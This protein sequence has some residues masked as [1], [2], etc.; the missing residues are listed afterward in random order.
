MD[1]T[2]RQQL[3][4]ALIPVIRRAG[5]LVRSLQETGVAPNFKPDGSPVT[6][7]DLASHEILCAGCKALAAAIPI[8]SEED[9]NSATQALKPLS[10]VIDPLDGTKEFVRGRDE[11]TI[12]IA[13]VENGHATAGLIY[14][15]AR[16]RLFFSY[17]NGYV[18]EEAPDGQC[19]DLFNRIVTP[20][21]PVVLVSRT[22]LDRQTEGLLST[23]QPCT[24]RKL[25][26]SLKF[27]LIAAAEADAYVRLSPTMLWDCAAG[28]ALVEAAG[29]AVLRTDGSPLLG[30]KRRALR[31]D[32]FI[33]ARTPQL[34]QRINTAQKLSL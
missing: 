20:R 4:E 33:A 18:F 9:E 15:P 21:R 5:A 27:A 30:E 29:G 12:N 22:H 26:S 28:L 24:I 14:A 1:L 23:L 17:G 13:L 6:R 25:G 16:E 34:A 32:G 19:R 3:V 2:S 31:I 8:I 11:F 7:A 10:F